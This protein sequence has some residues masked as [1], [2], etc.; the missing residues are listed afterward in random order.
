MD[1]TE[2]SSSLLSSRRRFGTLPSF[3]VQ[4]HLPAKPKS[5]D[6]KKVDY[7]L[8]IDIGDLSYA[9]PRQKDMA[10][11]FV[12]F[13]ASNSKRIL[14]NYLYVQNMMQLAQIPT[15][16][17]E[18]Y[19]NTPAIYKS[20]RIKSDSVLFHKERL[21]YLLEKQ[22]PKKYNKLLFLD[23]D[24]LFENP[25]WYDDISKALDTFEVVHPFQTAKWLD[26]TYTKVIRQGESVMV[27][28]QNKVKINTECHVGFGW[29]FQREWFN[30]IGFYQYCIIGSGDSLST[31]AWFKQMPERLISDVNSKYEMPAYSAFLKSIN[32]IP[33]ITNVKGV[34]YHLF[35]G[36]IANRNYYNRHSIFKDVAD[37][38][39][40][41][42]VDE[43]GL[44]EIT[45]PEI[46]QKVMDYFKA[47]ND[48]GV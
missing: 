20:F 42:R 13:N 38:R 31:M 21:C 35:H 25:L 27:N 33:K 5:I 32:R 3:S 11:C 40:I 39:D 15:F 28:E 9:M 8:D 2:S 47:R 24:I 1:G 30:R 44:F 4:E 34:I 7:P 29:A 48:D 36:S 14:M 16:T 41:L 37:L 46:A 6:P 10:V 26:L 17:I 43:S 22:V 18:V 23:A 19:K 45:D 12:Y